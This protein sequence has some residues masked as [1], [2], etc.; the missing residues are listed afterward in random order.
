MGPWIGVIA[1]G[2]ENAKQRVKKGFTTATGTF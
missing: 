1:G 2:T